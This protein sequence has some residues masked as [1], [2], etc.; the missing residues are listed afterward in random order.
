MP[1]KKS[2]VQ[3]SST[4]EPQLMETVEPKETSGVSKSKKNVKWIYILF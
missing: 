2:V 3:K 4:S 1:A